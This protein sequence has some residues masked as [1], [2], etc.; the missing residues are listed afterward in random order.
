MCIICNQPKQR[1]SW[2]V[3]QEIEGGLLY[4]KT[5]EINKDICA[6]CFK[7]ESVT[8]IKGNKCFISFSEYAKDFEEGFWA[9]SSFNR[10]DFISLKDG[11]DILNRNGIVNT[12]R[13]SDKMKRAKQWVQDRNP[14][15]LFQMAVPDGWSMRLQK[16]N[17]IFKKDFDFLLSLPP[18]KIDGIL[19]MNWYGSKKKHNLS[20]E[21][22]EELYR[23]GWVRFGFKGEPKFGN[24]L[25]EKKRVCVKCGSIKSFDDFRFN[26]HCRVWECLECESIRCHN[27]YYSL[28]PE[29][30]EKKRAYAREIRKSK[31]S[32]KKDEELKSRTDVR[33]WTYC[34]KNGLKSLTAVRKK[35]RN[36]DSPEVKW[37]HSGFY[38]GRGCDGKYWDH[39]YENLF[40]LYGIENPM[41]D[42]SRRTYDND[43]IF[44]VS[45]FFAYLPLFRRVVKQCNLPK[46]SVR[47]QRMG[48]GGIEDTNTN[49][50]LNL[51]PMESE[52]NRLKSANVDPEEI[53]EH[54]GKLA[55]IMPELFP[56]G[57]IPI[58]TEEFEKAERNHEY[59]VSIRNSVKIAT[60]ETNHEQMILGV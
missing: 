44:P 16:K 40:V 60:I 15:L 43:H 24:H 21:R 29:E 23:I 9:N 54:Y 7:I 12:P 27:A 52:K 56:N 3:E 32:K 25:I 8:E 45:K 53:N 31:K 49:N 46:P 4:K 42:N 14:A 6:D 37:L 30:L 17:F 33:D 34:K 59:Y 58:P 18:V 57:Y 11:Y 55:K 35:A 48:Y 38:N 50:F 5:I 26:H 22:I 47:E 20:E 39:Y 10:D 28:P 2:E 51:R 36:F 19:Q 41:G 1:K 13:E